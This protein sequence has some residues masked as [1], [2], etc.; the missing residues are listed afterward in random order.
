MFVESLLSGL[1]RDIL[2]S[3]LSIINIPGYYGI[4]HVSF[5]DPS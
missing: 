5:N 3:I 2:H 1:D 4:I